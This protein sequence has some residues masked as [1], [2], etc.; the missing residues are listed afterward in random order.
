CQ[1][2]QINSGIPD[3][4]VRHFDVNSFVTATWA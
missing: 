1:I 2:L 3:V 4:H